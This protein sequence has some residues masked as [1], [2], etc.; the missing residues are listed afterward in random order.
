MKRTFTLHLHG[1]N[2]VNTPGGETMLAVQFFNEDNSTTFTTRMK[3]QEA[4]QLD[5]DGEFVLTLEEKK[6][7]A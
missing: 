5:F 4:A 2:R 6:K 1:T 7:S 3:P